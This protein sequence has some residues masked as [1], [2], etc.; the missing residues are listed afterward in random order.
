MKK[1]VM[2]KWV[3][4]LRSGKYEQGTG[5]LNKHNELCCLGVLCEVLET[6][7]VSITNGITCYGSNKSEG[8]V[9]TLPE[10]IKELAGMISSCGLYCRGPSLIE[11][12][13]TGKNFN[14]I[15]DII[16]QNWDKL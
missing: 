5:Y 7:K 1:D 13:D 4:A 15:A 9:A 12:N 2:V 3:E 11:A 14:E 10:S 16:E 8:T 6:P